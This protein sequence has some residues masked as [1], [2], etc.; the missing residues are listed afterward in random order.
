MKNLSDDQIFLFYDQINH[1]EEH[2]KI[3]FKFFFFLNL[4]ILKF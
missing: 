2:P 1:S 4:F 3:F